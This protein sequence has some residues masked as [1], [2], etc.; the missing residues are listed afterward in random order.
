[1]KEIIN[2]NENWLFTKNDMTD[3]IN[4]TDF[5]GEEINLPHTW[6]AVDGVEL[7]YHKG[8]CWYKKVV[9]SVFDD[10]KVFIEFQGS[11]SITEVF[12]N[13][14]FAGRHEGGYSCFR[15]EITEFIE[16]RMNTIIVKVDNRISTEIYPMDADFTLYGG[17]YRDVNIIVTDS[18][19]FELMDFGSKGIYITPDVQGR[20]AYINIVSLI[21]GGR[22]ET[23]AEYT[24]LDANGEKLSIM[25]KDSNNVDFDMT[26][27]NAK[28]WKGK[29]NPYLYTLRARLF[30][31]EGDAVYDQ[32]EIPFGVRYF[33]VESETGFHLNSKPYRLYGVSRHQDRAGIGN[34]FLPEHHEEDMALIKEMGA[35]CI[36]LAH[37]Q[38][39]DYFYKLCDE[40]GMVVWTEIPFITKESLTKKAKQNAINQLN[41]LIKQ[42]YNHPSICFWGVQNVANTE[43]MGLQQLMFAKKLAS[44]AK[45]LDKKRLT[46][47]TNDSAVPD[48][49]PYNS[50]TDLVGYNRDFS[51][52]DGDIKQHYEWLDAFH[53][54]NK[55]LK[56]CLSEY[57]TEGDVQLHAEEPKDGD[58]TEEYHTQYHEKVW[59]E[60]EKRPF[61]W[62]SFAGKMFDFGSASGGPKGSNNQGLVT[63]DRGTK[64]DAFY[65]YKMNWAKEKL[66]HICGKRFANRTT[67][68]TMLK[69]Y[70]SCKTISI[71]INSDFYSSIDSDKS[72]FEIPIDL[73]MGE[74]RITIN[75]DFGCGDTI[76]ITRTEP[77]NEDIKENNVEVNNV[78]V[79]ND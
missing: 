65:Y 68:S 62:A 26:I 18:V 41:E 40:E 46:V 37:Y 63:F 55:K 23:G 34:A 61:I 14:H 1:M 8:A 53:N 25:H 3:A 47:S 27:K 59:P 74:N 35:N 29:D 4:G 2:I 72:V 11:N 33:R 28:L 32:I 78:E 51:S 48:L 39:S 69:V 20:D 16:G 70:A 71:Y 10:K 45:K 50:I 24:I 30:S 31:L 76:T 43:N 22:E 56:L 66:V 44:S 36:R 42:N 5:F 9:D 67:A 64:K 12:V 57:G 21:T 13:G 38:Q 77:L 75:S 58:F 7:D 6:N 15:F 79:N 54:K 73:K 17:I 49:S 60:I 52:S 19:H